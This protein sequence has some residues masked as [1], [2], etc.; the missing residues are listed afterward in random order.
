MRFYLAGLCFT[1]A[2]AGGL[3]FHDNLSL[4]V[5]SYVI[6]AAGSY[7]ALEMID[8]WR[9]TRGIRA[10]YWQFASAAALGGSIWSMHFEQVDRLLRP[11]GCVR[12]WPIIATTSDAPV[13][14]PSV[15]A[16]HDDCLS[17]PKLPQYG[18]PPAISH[19]SYPRRSSPR[20]R[21]R[22]C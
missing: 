3:A 20:Y 2:D 21:S 9:N 17:L 5:L 19:I 22:C 1:N 6:A 10:C 12:A 16:A 7:A 13:M 4:A 18:S 15:A 8:R 11:H 14:T